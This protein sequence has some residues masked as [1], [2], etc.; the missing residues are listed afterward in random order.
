[1]LQARKA[2]RGGVEAILRD[3][4]VRQ[5]I[6]EAQTLYS[7]VDLLAVLTESQYPLELWNDLKSRHPAVAER[8]AFTTPQ[9]LEALDLEGVFRLIQSVD[10]PRA[11]RLQNWMAAA[12]RQRLEEAED[13]EL[14]LLRTRRAYE[15]QGRSRQWIDQRMRSASARHE[16]T[17][18]WYRRGVHEGEEF[19][20]LTN[21]MMASAFGMDV[22]G[23]RRYKGLFRTGQNLRD[24]MTDLELALTALG[25]TTAVELHR[26]RRSSGFDALLLD[27]KDTGQLIAN[28]RHEIEQHIGRP[29]VSAVNFVG[30]PGPRPPR[31]PG[32]QLRNAP[33]DAPQRDAVIDRTRDLAA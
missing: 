7:A 9:G 22:E 5:V 33:T 17:A 28:T 12:A 29:V 26:R 2:S 18:E 24:H 8:V 32:A 14:A 19:R 15:Q 27:A 13:P 1:M 20:A 11:Q 6:H 31:R 21:Q 30:P 25:E 4:R 23:Y 16:L 3:P 10:S